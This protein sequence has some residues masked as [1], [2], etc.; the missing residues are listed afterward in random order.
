[1]SEGADGEATGEGQVLGNAKGRGS[2][3]RPGALGGVVGPVWGQ[4]VYSCLAH[5]VLSGLMV[6]YFEQGLVTRAL[7]AQLALPGFGHTSVCHAKPCTQGSCQ[8]PLIL[9]S[10]LTLWAL[11][12]SRL[13]TPYGTSGSL[14]SRQEYTQECRLALFP[15]L[16]MPHAHIPLGPLSVAV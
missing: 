4:L 10:A 5:M 2:S 15:C 1:M 3:D 9:A 6:P 11:N 16:T 13:C 8:C 7:L 12:L 14:L